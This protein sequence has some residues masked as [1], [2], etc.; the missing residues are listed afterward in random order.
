[1]D[2]N[3]AL[4]IFSDPKSAQQALERPGK[5]KLRPFAEVLPPVSSSCSLTCTDDLATNKDMVSPVNIERFE[6]VRRLQENFNFT[7]SIYYHPRALKYFL[8][9]MTDRPHVVHQDA[10]TLW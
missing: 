8:F 10:F 4:A 7:S 5:Y 6:R 1:M 9:S 2:D 3:H